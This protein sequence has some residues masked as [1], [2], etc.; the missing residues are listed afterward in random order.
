MIRYVIRSM[1]TTD[2]VLGSNEWVKPYPIYL[3]PPEKRCG[4]YW[5]RLAAAMT[6]D[7]PE[8]ANHEG[9]HLSERVISTLPR[10]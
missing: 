6:G 8:A 10:R 2:F 9:S 7:R 5:S 4:A 3:L 1:S